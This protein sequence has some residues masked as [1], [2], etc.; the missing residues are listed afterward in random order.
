MA[1]AAARAIIAAVSTDDELRQSLAELASVIDTLLTILV[2]KGELN[3]GHLRVIQ[4][5]KR[6]AK[7]ATAPQIALDHTTDKYEVEGTG[8]DID[9][10]AR[11][12][13]CLGR[14]CS[15]QIPLSQQDLREG[16]LEWQI[17]RPYYLAR[18]RA[19]LCT[20][21]SEQ[22]GGCTNYE[23]RPATCR[24]YDCR[25]DKRVWLD[26]ENMIPAPVP[27]GLVTIR[28]PVRSP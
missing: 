23:H 15:F 20:Y 21:Q 8:A 10:A 9:C 11:M 19:G 16:K 28:L 2:Q 27:E 22:T 5:L 17:D 7:A 12:H 1:R 25:E 14:C 4:K 6:Y 26:F 18:T 13:L 24:R 3:E